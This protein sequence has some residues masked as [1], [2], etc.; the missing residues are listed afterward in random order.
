[1]LCSL[2]QPMQHQSLLPKYHYSYCCVYRW[3]MSKARTQQRP[4]D[5]EKSELWDYQIARPLT[6][7]CQNHRNRRPPSSL[8]LHHVGTSTPV[9][10]SWISPSC[11]LVA[12]GGLQ[13]LEW[14][15]CGVEPWTPNELLH[16][17]WTNWR[18]RKWMSAMPASRVTVIHTILNKSLD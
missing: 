12:S 3:S 17:D 1:M 7:F 18:S 13:E 9:L 5:W 2:W 15:S 11:K 8:G 10:W 16:S 6:T 4:A 14:C